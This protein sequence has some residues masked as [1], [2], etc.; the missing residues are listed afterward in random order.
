MGDATAVVLLG[1]RTPPLRWPLRDTPPALA[2]SAN[3]AVLAHQIEALTRLGFGQI[4]I[5]GDATSAE[6]AYGAL[7]SAGIDPETIPYVSLGAINGRVPLAPAAT[8]FAA[9]SPLVLIEPGTL[10]GPDLVTV[11][12]GVSRDPRKAVIVSLPTDD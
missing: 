3:R 6:R 9:D 2:P 10:P 7:R 8:Y 1:S 5:A 12:D 4:A 11:V